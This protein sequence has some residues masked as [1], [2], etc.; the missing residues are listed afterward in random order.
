MQF[1]IWGKPKGKNRPRFGQGRIYTAPAT[2]EYEDR[3]KFEY[4]RQCRNRR[5][6]GNVKVEIVAYTEPQKALP[7][8][9]REELIGQFYPL[10]P[11][12]DNIEKIVL[13]ALNGVAYEDDKQVVVLTCQKFYAEQSK[14]VADIN[15]VEENK[16]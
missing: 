3:V 15:E 2:K 9:K 10:K 16:K 7:K 12:C 4:A 14:V 8:K 11:D 13:D 5:F 6:E 1:T